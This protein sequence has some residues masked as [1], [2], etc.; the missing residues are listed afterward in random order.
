MSF[1]KPWSYTDSAN[2]HRRGLT[3]G[4][5]S[6]QS[7]INI[8]PK[9]TSDCNM[10]CNIA[11]KYSSSK[12]VATVKNKTPII[13]FDP[14]SYLKFIKN[15]DILSLKAMTIH[16]P[17][18]HSFDGTFYDMEVVLYHKLSGSLN[19]DS[20][21][22]VPGGTAISLLFQRGV[23]YGAQNNF[24]NSFIYK[25]PIDKENINNQFDIK[26]GDNWG[27]EMIIPQI[28]T[29]Y[30]YAGSLP[31]PPAEEN[32]NW[33]VFEEIQQISGNIID[34]LKVAFNNNTRP[35]QPLNSRVPAYNANVEFHFDR[36]LENKY[37]KELAS[38]VS[39][40]KIKNKLDLLNNNDDEVS[41]DKKMKIASME[42]ARLAEWYKSRKMYF[43]GIFISIIF[44]LIIYASLKFVKYIVNNDILNKIM[45]EQALKTKSKETEFKPSQSPSS[46][47]QTSASQQKNNKP[48]SA[49]QSKNSENNNSNMSNNSRN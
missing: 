42:K 21:N 12:C 49:V 41:A 19:K 47:K 2:W 28:K 13:Y 8:I 15:K 14:G 25:V 31:F 20:E 32:W 9:E 6:N 37:K 23:D 43:K 34:T 39:D 48:N 5:G 33:I 10:L 29:Y 7:P 4:K 46:T 35:I 38:R 3:D 1:N 36:M 27:P 40:D 11:L 17:S 44:L 30:Y 18:L 26:V 16:T 45:V 22:W 24:F